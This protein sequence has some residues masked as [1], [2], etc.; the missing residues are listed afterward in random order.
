ME[1]RREGERAAVASGAPMIFAELVD[2]ERLRTL[3]ESFTALTGAVTAV[4]DLD[5]R[6]LVATGWQDIC[7]RFHRACPGS[8]DRCRESDTVLANRLHEG[9]RWTVYECKNGLVDVAVPIVV[10]GE[11]VANF[12][13]GQFLFQPAEPGRFER[14]AAEFGY[15]L[16]AY[17]AALGRV[18]VFSEEHVRK[19]MDFLGRLAAVF[20]EMGL[21][22]KGIEAAAHRAS[23]SEERFALAMEATQD[24]LWD[25]TIGT[26]AIYY[27]PGYARML[28][29]QPSELPEPFSSWQELVHPEDR[30]RVEQANQDCIENRAARFR[31]EF[32]MR[33]RDGSW[34]WIVSRGSAVTRDDAGR[35]LRMIGT[36][37]D[38]TERRRAEERSRQLEGQLAQAQ[39]MESVGRLAGGVAHDFNN[40]LAVILGHT[41]LAREQALAVDPLRSDLEEI[42]KAASR[43]ADLTR[44]LLTFARKQEIVPVALDLNRTVEDLLK[45]L[46]RLIGENIA[47]SWRPGPDLWTVNA[48]PTQMDQVVTNLC[49]NARGAIADVGQIAIETSNLS[50]DEIASSAHV[51]TA[52]GDYVRLSV[53]DTGCGMDAETQARIFEPFFTTRGSQGGTGLGLATVYGA[54]RQNGGFVE[55]RSAP[56]LGATFTVFLPRHAGK[57]LAPGAAVPLPRGGRATI[58][59]VEDEPAVLV[60]E[61]KMLERLSYQVLCASSPA[62]AVRLAE[63][64][65][66]KIDLLLTDVVMPEMNGRD[67]ASRLL[68]LR[69]GLRCLYMSGYTADVIANQ[70]VLEP[71]VHFVQK[72]FSR[73]QL[74]R[75]V[76]GALEHP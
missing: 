9:E 1:E 65:S 62:E 7:T 47:V 13:T 33:H 46:Q 45:M 57:V 19:L 28:G 32:R 3:C 68:L 37:T 52:P 23:E 76:R 26:G 25:R 55:V 66:G 69:P 11:H 49:L 14:Q 64:H 41:E 39:K 30:L 2:L 74:A 63:Q 58:L 5:G 61:R 18:P 72:P 44:Q 6:V 15:D 53:R 17:L 4:L 59:V 40:M 27:S 73:D 16:D 70:G 56:G 42:H 48:D 31:V 24:G 20:G 60:V 35:V 21:V 50:L 29:Y 12:F 8:A 34:R 54:V 67:L 10:G 71:D 75:A 36:H 38:V 43:S 22:R 51:G